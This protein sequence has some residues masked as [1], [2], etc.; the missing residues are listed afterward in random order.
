MT[1]G[2]RMGDRKEK[3]YGLEGVVCCTFIRYSPTGVQR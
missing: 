2:Y 1:A 3:D